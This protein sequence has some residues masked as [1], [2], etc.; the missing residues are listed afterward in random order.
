VGPYSQL[1]LGDLRVAAGLLLVLL[2]ANRGGVT[3]TA[4]EAAAG[5]RETG[6]SGERGHPQTQTDMST[7]RCICGLANPEGI[8]EGIH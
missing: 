7:S 8:F 2:S 4:G 5:G 6:R 1:T 3:S